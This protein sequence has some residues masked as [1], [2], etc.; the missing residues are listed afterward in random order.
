MPTAARVAPGSP[1]V[2]GPGN[3]GNPAGNVPP[4]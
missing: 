3:P 4:V 1:R 2:S